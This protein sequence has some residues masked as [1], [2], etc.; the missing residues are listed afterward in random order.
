MARSGQHSDHQSI[1]VELRRSRDYWLARYE[2][3]S[4]GVRKQFDIVC[5]EARKR[6]RYADRKGTAVRP[7]SLVT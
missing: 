7:L 3:E 1:F 4:P 6:A 5:A 2:L